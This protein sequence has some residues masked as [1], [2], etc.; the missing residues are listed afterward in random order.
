[1]SE[2][3]PVLPEEIFNVHPGQ[4]FNDLCLKIFHF[5]YRQNRVYQQFCD[6]LERNPGNVN[7]PSEIP[8]LPIEFFKTHAVVCGE[9]KPDVV[10]SSS[11]TSGSQTSRHAVLSADLYD[12]SFLKGFT[13]AYGDPG[14]YCFLALLPSYLEREGSSLIYMV[15]KLMQISRHPLNGFFLYDHPKLG[16]ALQHLR[17]QNQK[18]ILFGVS[19]ALIDFT[20][21]FR[22]DFPE[23]IVVE[24]G[25]MKGRKKEMIREELHELLKAGFGVGQIHSEYGMTELLSQAWSAGDGHFS[26]PPWMKVLIRDVNDPM[27][28]LMAGRTGGISII[29]LANLYSC[30]F[31][32]TSDLG[33]IRPDATFEVLGRYDQSEIRGCNLMAGGA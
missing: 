32:A 1:M 7:K 18:T 3:A 12:Q 14:Q 15:E 11:G 28:Y 6:H 23:L 4:M 31:I 21:D 19:Y 30:S 33:M 24:T 25:G 5:Q 9:K 20:Q 2:T 10:F 29:D 16:E 13:L 27:S 17:N 22:I 8:F 26:T